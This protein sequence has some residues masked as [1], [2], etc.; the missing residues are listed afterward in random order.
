MAWFRLRLTEEKQRVVDEER[1]CHPNLPIREKLL[2]FCLVV[3]H[4]ADA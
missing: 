3:A 2:A 1:C 4:W